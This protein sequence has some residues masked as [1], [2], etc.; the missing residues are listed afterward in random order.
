MSAV[1][2]PDAGLDDRREASLSASNPFGCHTSHP[3]DSCGIDWPPERSTVAAHIQRGGAHGEVRNGREDFTHE[4]E[5]QTRSLAMRT[6][7]PTGT[8]VRRRI[9]QALHRNADLDARHI[10][11]NVSGDVVTLTGAVGSWLQREA[12]GRGAASA[13]G[14]RSVE[15]RIAV[16]PSEPHEIEPPD[17]IC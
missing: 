7:L 12:A 14:I 13:P 5:S 1:R 3:E 6:A 11:V 2:Y 17:E 16:V 8:D 9:V 15:N 10:D 4:S